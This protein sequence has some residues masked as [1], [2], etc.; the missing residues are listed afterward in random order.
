VQS[1]DDLRYAPFHLL[2]TEGAVHADKDHS[3]HTGQLAELCRADPAFLVKTEGIIVETGDPA[4]TAEGLRWWLGLTGQGGEGMV[5]KPLPF[6]ARSPKRGLV[7]PAVKVRGPEY[8]RLIY[9]PDYREPAHLNRLRE[10]GLSAKRAL[11]LREFALG[12]E[13]LE[14]FVQR[15]PLRR[16]HECVLGV[17]ALES[18]PVDPRL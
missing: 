10:R 15:Q 9:G 2:A 12:L 7:Q 5:V 16:V 1:A 14:R 3:W 11:A 17:L 4:G 13:A 6:I 8:L 18:E